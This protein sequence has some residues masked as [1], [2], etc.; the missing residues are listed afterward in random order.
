MIAEN[1][2]KASW[3]LEERLAVSSLAALLTHPLTVSVGV[4]KGFYASKGVQVDSHF[5]ELALMNAAGTAFF[6]SEDNLSRYISHR[7]LA[8]QFSPDA[9]EYV[10]RDAK[11]ALQNAG[12]DA[13]KGG[14]IGAALTPI[15]FFIGYGIGLGLG[16]LDKLFS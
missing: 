2:V 4:Y 12:E 13:V 5:L 15:E 9:S 6:N 7:N 16:S 10:L 14:V 11:N 3:T 1:V 8:K